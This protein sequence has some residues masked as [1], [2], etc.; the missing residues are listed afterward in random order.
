[1]DL[2]IIRQISSDIILQIPSLNFI[3]K[4]KRSVL[5]RSRLS[6]F[7]LLFFDTERSILVAMLFKKMKIRG[8]G[9]ILRETFVQKYWNVVSITILIYQ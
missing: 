6:E 2:D 5:D 3:R 7:L 4:L 9:Y 1:M 8:G